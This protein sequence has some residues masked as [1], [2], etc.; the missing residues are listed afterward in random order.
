MNHKNNFLKII[1]YDL[2][3]SIRYNRIKLI[4][5][6]LIDI[7]I[8]ISLNSEIQNYV[9]VG[10]KNSSISF[11]DYLLYANKGMRNFI[12]EEGRL[13]IIP[14]QWLVINIF[15]SFLIGNY[16]TNELYGYGQQFLIREE[17]KFNFIFSK[18]L[19]AIYTTVFAYLIGYIVMLVFSISSSKILSIIPNSEFSLL[20]YALDIQNIS[21]ITF[22]FATVIQPI[23]ASIAI[24]FIQ[25]TLSWIVKPIV[26]YLSI[27]IYIII[28]AYFQSYLLL[29]NH[30]MMLRNSAVESGGLNGMVC[31]II[32]LIVIVSTFIF[33][34]YLFNLQD[35]IKK[36]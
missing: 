4:I 28:S 17:K 10:L 19:F 3:N 15:I 23:I 21:V 36:N 29:G 12:K 24:S 33:G 8:C 13:F 20:A 22:I 5:L 25:I 14:F 7:A 1:M 16:S 31:V 11:G 2:K 9:G 18:Y 32:D 35:I 26:S 6:V 27:V 30:S 34:V